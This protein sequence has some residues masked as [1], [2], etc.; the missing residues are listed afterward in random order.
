MGANDSIQ[1]I[2]M[3]L[4]TSEEAV[5]ILETLQPMGANRSQFEEKLYLEILRMLQSRALV[6]ANDAMVIYAQ[7]RV[8]EA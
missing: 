2:S 8:R 4:M 5:R 7:I 6:E 3:N 1:G